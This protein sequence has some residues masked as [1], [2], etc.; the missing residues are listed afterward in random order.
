MNLFRLPLN[1]FVV[2]VLS[3]ERHPSLVLMICAAALALASG[4]QVHPPFLSPHPTC[5][6]YAL[7]SSTCFP[8]C[9][10]PLLCPWLRMMANKF[11][12]TTTNRCKVMQVTQ[13]T[14][15]KSRKHP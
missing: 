6:T 9:A 10:P 7:A 8:A 4:L 3:K 2:V 12:L 5:I 15:L 13:R 11:L 1:I 14:L